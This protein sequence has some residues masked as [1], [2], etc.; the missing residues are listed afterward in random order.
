MMEHQIK[1]GSLKEVIDNMDLVIRTWEEIQ[2]MVLEAQI[3][4]H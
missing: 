3:Y 4:F 2:L 1:V